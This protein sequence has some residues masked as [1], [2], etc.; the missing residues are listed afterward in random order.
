MPAG[1]RGACHTQGHRTAPRPTATRRG[2]APL[3]PHRAR[4]AP[5]PSR[6]PPLPRGRAPRPPH[7]SL[8]LRISQDEIAPEDVETAREEFSSRHCVPV[9]LPPEQA[10]RAEVLSA[11][12]LW[13]LFHYIPLSM[14]E[15]DTDMIHRAPSPRPLPPDLARSRPTLPTAHTFRRGRTSRPLRLIRR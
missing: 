6:A 9:L 11:E 12:V 3:A 2:S 15:S 8:L 4:A 7:A 1:G 10:E 14:L 13:P 5:A